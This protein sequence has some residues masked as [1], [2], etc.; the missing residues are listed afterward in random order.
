MWII[1][2]GFIGPLIRKGQYGS[3]VF[4]PEQYRQIAQTCDAVAADHTLPPAQRTAYARKAD[5]YRMLSR[6][7]DK[8]KWAMPTKNL[9]KFHTC[10]SKGMEIDTSLSLLSAAL[11]SF[12]PWQQRR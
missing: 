9:D 7:G 1:G 2:F 5:W 11:R 8:P 10:Q 12:L 6:L 4:T 3:M